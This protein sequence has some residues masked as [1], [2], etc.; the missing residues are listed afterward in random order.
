MI[1]AGWIAWP[2]VLQYRLGQDCRHSC[3]Q[4][5]AV[6]SS[7]HIGRHCSM[8]QPVGRETADIS[9]SSASYLPVPF[10]PAIN[11]YSYLCHV[12]MWIDWKCEKVSK[13]LSAQTSIK[14]VLTWYIKRSMLKLSNKWE[15]NKW[16]KEDRKLSFYEKCCQVGP[17]NWHILD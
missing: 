7:E 3:I 14:I 8:I 17:L 11:I 6:I 13:L 2:E 10:S 9:S 5:N 12:E 1:R 15:N 4:H 16:E